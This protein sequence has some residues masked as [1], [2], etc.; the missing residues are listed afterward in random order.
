MT[1]ATIR[2]DV[3][4]WLAFAFCLAFALA[5]AGMGFGLLAR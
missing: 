4:L 3:L 2:F 1:A 5:S